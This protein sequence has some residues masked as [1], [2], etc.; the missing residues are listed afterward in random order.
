[1][2]PGTGGVLSRNE[3][4][5]EVAHPNWSASQGTCA[6][7]PS[8]LYA[9][10][11]DDGTVFLEETCLVARPTLPFAVLKRR[12]ERRCAAM[13]IRIKEV[14]FLLLSLCL[15]T[16][17]CSL[18]PCVSKCRSKN[19]TG[20]GSARSVSA[21]SVSASKTAVRAEKQDRKQG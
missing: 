17:P 19:T 13:G 4:D 20:V 14:F 7:P 6:E 18:A 8:F 16:Q 2:W 12:L 11:L 1:M 21:S 15:K 9:M 5:G 10:P 3:A